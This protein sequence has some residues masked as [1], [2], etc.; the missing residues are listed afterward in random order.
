MKIEGLE[1]SEITVRCS[2]CKLIIRQGTNPDAIS[3]G[4]C[5]ECLKIEKEKNRILKKE[6]VL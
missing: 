1:K 6:G 4:A 2:Y 5:P 3:D